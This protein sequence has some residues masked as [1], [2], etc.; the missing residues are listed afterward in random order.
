MDNIRKIY[1]VENFYKKKYLK[2][3]LKYFELKNKSITLLPTNLG[4][5]ITPFSLNIGTLLFNESNVMT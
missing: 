1:K 5:D 4:F 2:Y 3:K